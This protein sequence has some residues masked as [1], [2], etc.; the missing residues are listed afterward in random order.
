MQSRI[1][2][3][4]VAVAGFVLPWIA[5]SALA[6][7]PAPAV[8]GQAP[9]PPEANRPPVFWREEWKHQGDTS[10]SYGDAV[11]SL[12]NVTNASLEMKVYG[13]EP[14]PDTGTAPNVTHTH[15]GMWLNKRFKEDP[16]HIFTGT[17]NRPCGLTFKHKTQYVNLADFGT[18]IRWLVKFAGYHQIRP[19]IKLA[20]GTY[21]VGDHTDGWVEAYDWYVSEISIASLRWRRFDPEKVITVTGPGTDA[22]VWFTNPDLS[23]VDEVGFVDLMPGSGHGPGGYSDVG[24]I[25]VTGR[26]VPRTASTSG[27]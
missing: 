11:L 8:R 7:T 5:S 6:Q 13:E 10:G 1:F 23:K 17:C 24:W 27:R 12:Q 25:E 2:K 21:L 3:V 22:K 15:A 16:A 18:K 20:D 26:P 4:S 19:L 9:A 14:K